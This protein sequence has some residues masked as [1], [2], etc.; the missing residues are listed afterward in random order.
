M[1]N[2]GF[3]AVIR[4]ISTGFRA[5]APLPA[6]A[7]RALMASARLWRFWDMGLK[8][9]KHLLPGLCS[10]RRPGEA[11][12]VAVDLLPLLPGGANGGA[13]VLTVNLLE[14][15]SAMAPDWTFI[16]VCNRQAM[17]EL[18]SLES[19]NV[20]IVEA[21]RAWQVKPPKKLLGRAIDVW[22]CPFT[23][24]YF[25][26][27]DI[28]LVSTLYDLQY[29]YYPQFFS[30]EER[31][32]RDQTFQLAA[33]K[34]TR[35]A[36]ISDYVRGTV[37]EYGNVIPEK[38]RTVYIRLPQRLA[39]PVPSHIAE[40]LGPLKLVQGNYLIY[41]ANFWEHKNHGML[42]TAFG[43]FAQAHPGSGL[44]LVLTG[45]DSGKA[46]QLKQAAAAMGL[47]ERV[48]FTG[49]IEDN[50]LAALLCGALA[51]IFPS[52]FEGYGMPVAEAM[53]LGVPVLCSNVTSLPEVGGGAALYFDPRKPEDMAAAIARIATQPGLAG[54]LA[55]KGL[56][57]AAEMGGPQDMAR[58]YLELLDEAMRGLGVQSAACDGVGPAGVCGRVFAAFGPASAR[59]TLEASFANNGSATVQFEA[60]CNGKLIK[61]GGEIAPGKTAD[62]THTASP[63]GG[64]LEVVFT[65]CAQ[66]ADVV[67]GLA[68]LKLRL[69][70][71]RGYD[72]L[73][74]RA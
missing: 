15:M 4:D 73:A 17:A 13:K 31:R 62:I 1:N 7:E 57:R 34:A 43:L 59:Q 40:V 29:H 53:S 46:A 22:F 12:L 37:L 36:C 61:A 64:C 21:R 5:E 70:G 48:V 63:Y 39:A 65:G 50:G 41:P 11:P 45:H 42:L 58:D 8:A 35:L 56:A 32:C 23:R 10:G 55:Q 60:Y 16:L 66:Q 2:D 33:R 19:G 47:G 25:Q 69:T 72:F 28:A 14:T 18:G 38:V 67:P 24:P 49:Y 68:C 3:K 20:K 71:T 51:L 44:R 9:V 27:S 26:H 52:L 6:L 30:D 54:Q 74:P